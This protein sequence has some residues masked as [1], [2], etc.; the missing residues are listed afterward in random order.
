M[1]PSLNKIG[2]FHSRR[3]TNHG[4][5]FF[6]KN[7]SSKTEKS[8]NVK[9]GKTWF[10]R[11][12][13][14]I[15][16]DDLIFVLVIEGQIDG[17]KEIHVCSFFIL[18]SYS[19]ESSCSSEKVVSPFFC[20]YSE[21]RYNPQSDKQNRISPSLAWTDITYWKLTIKGYFSHSLRLVAETFSL[22]FKCIEFYVEEKL[23]ALGTVT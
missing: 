13:R 7:K 21:Y 11:K 2:C 3:R 18:Y 5:P 1:S 17:Q 15:S 10:E 22:N 14:Q 19:S 6:W 8:S 16:F 4:R 20:L 23:K 12:S 9:K